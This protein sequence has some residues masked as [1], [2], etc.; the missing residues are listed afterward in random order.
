MSGDALIGTVLADRYRIDVLLGE[1]GMGR[2]YGAEHILMRKR[3]AVKILHRQLTQVPEVVARFEREAMAAAHIDHPNIAAATDFGKLA[4]GAVF[5]VLEYV[6]GRSLRDEIARGPL[7]PA[8]ALHIA[9]QIA[10]ALAAAHA[11]E[12]V[13]RDLKPENVMLVQKGTD[14]DFVKV[15]DFGI[16]KV[17]I[18]EVEG[19]ANKP[20]T[21]AGMV[22]GTPE[23]MAPE[24]ALGQPVDGRADLFAFGVMLFEMLAG[25]RPYVAKNQVAILG[26]MLSQPVP[27][28]SQRAP[29]V[30]VPPTVESFVHRLLAREV[31]ERCQSA[32]E[33]YVCIETLLGQVP[34]ADGRLF[35]LAGGSPTA[36]VGGP[37][38]YRDSAAQ[39]PSSLLSRGSMPSIADS[40]HEL[41]RPSMARSSS[42]AVA[43][44]LFPAPPPPTPDIT[45][46]ERII[47]RLQQAA[48]YLETRKRELPPPLDNVVRDVPGRV[49]LGAVAFGVLGIVTAVIAV[50]VMLSRGDAQ[51]QPA[52]PAASGAPSAS[53]EA[54]TEA[55][56]N[57]FEARLARAETEGL[58]AVEALARELPAEGS[59]LVAL[60]RARA[61]AGKFEEAVSAVSD[62]LAIDPKLNESPRIAGVLFRCA[63]APAASSATF[64]LLEG[65]MGTRGADIIYDL[66]NTRGVRPAVKATAEKL[67]RSKDFQSASSPALEVAVA[68]RRA[69]SCSEYSKLLQPAKNVGDARSLEFLRPLTAKTGC[70]TNKQSDCYECLRKNDALAQT[71]ATIEKRS[72]TQK[73][74][75]E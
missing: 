12:I 41:S 72:A 39:M 44:D 28:F 74:R 24:Q 56:K 17:P 20:I 75:T 7:S 19:D 69:D 58:P 16:A 62:A 36:V 31:D 71:I 35:T 2:V 65:P 57:A 27:T 6:E 50:I 5:L 1:G 4:D 64:R 21:K 33:A 51:E 3:L 9:R 18:G 63:Q 61:K 15:L 26:Q 10:A 49:L 43:P 23:Y 52:G 38:S 37:S 68:L 60:A 42:A 29:G 48:K 13:H 54:R 45:T 11:L 46:A 14:S 70:G 25:V 66:A 34:Q 47:T 32:A 53:V 30:S 73:P 67:L 40:L 55:P 22:Y 8:R 59:V